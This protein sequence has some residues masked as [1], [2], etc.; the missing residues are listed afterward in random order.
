M[1]IG[2]LSS[3]RTFFNFVVTSFSTNC[4][5]A[6]SHSMKRSA[7]NALRR[8]ELFPDFLFGVGVSAGIDELK[9]RFVH[10]GLCDRAGEK[11][12]ANR[13]DQNSML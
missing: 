1:E 7:V 8:L 2:A 4:S 6:K 11:R 9:E 13:S 3:S 10:G 5:E 12:H